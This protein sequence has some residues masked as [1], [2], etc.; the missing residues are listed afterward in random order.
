MNNKVFVGGLDYGTTEK[1][2]CELLESYGKVLAL[3]I[4]SDRETGKSKGYGFVTFENEEQ[5]TKAI[6]NLDNTEFDGRR[7]GVKKAV[8]K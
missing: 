8:D 6:D 3:R 2:L 1:K 5:A 7:I 4:I